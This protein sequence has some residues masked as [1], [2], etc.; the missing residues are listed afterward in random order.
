MPIID[1]KSSK[2]HGIPTP[3]CALARNDMFFRQSEKKIGPRPAFLF[4]AGDFDSI[5][6]FVP[7]GKDNYGSVRPLNWCMIATG[8][9]VVV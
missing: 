6:I 9:P 1:G 4:G 5:R 2:I 7:E 3:V 8:N